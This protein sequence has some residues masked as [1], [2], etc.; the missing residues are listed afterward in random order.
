M[1]FLQDSLDLFEGRK[2]SHMGAHQY[3]PHAGKRNGKPTSGD[4][5]WAETEE[6]HNVSS[7]AM[8]NAETVLLRQ[9]ASKISQFIP[10]GLPVVDLGPGTVQAFRN[11][12]QPLMQAIQSEQ[13]IPVDESIVFLQDLFHSKD[14]KEKYSVRPMIDNFFENESPYHEGSALVCSFGSTISN[15]ENPMSGN[16]PEEA[17][18]K[19]LY[20]MALAAN[21]G[22]LL[23]AFDSNQNGENIKEYYRLHALF[24]LNIFDR[25]AV[26]LPMKNFDALAF[27]YEPIWIPA[28]S[29]LAHT[30]IV[31]RNTDFEIGDKSIHLEKGQR[32][33]LKN[34]YKFETAFFEKACRA[35]QLDILRVWEDDSTSKV[36][37]LRLPTYAASKTLVIPS[38]SHTERAVA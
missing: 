29:Q 2:T 31:T 32:L 22:A 1:N 23:V 4:R 14:I 33:H 37:L 18:I 38:H 9:A 21:D 28:S 6:Q 13:Y 15:I 8:F 30:A 25:M 10:Q 36:Y 27:D 3:V 16:L 12:V 19:G 34:S 35:L 11:K 20:R 17:L 26:E 24:Q 7:K 5:L